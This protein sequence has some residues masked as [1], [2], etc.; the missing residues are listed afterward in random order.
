[1]HHYFS[2]ESPPCLADDPTSVP[3]AGL[4]GAHGSVVRRPGHSGRSQRRGL[5]TR[6]DPQPGLP[7]ASAALGAPGLHLGS[8]RPPGDVRRH[9]EADEAAGMSCLMLVGAA[10]RDQRLASGRSTSAV[11]SIRFLFFANQVQSSA[12]KQCC[13]MLCNVVRECGTV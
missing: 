5:A 12:Q 4:E 6:S 9:A 11:N 1:M 3:R 13:E 7:E 8:G 10:A 2:Q